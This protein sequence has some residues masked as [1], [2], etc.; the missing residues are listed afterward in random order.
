[1]KVHIMLLPVLF[2]VFSAVI[3]IVPNDG[4][5]IIIIGE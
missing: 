4:G 3:D 2:V 1:M 5:N